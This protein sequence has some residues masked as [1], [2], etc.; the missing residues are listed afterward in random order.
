MT[1]SSH[2]LC[3]TQSFPWLSSELGYPKKPKGWLGTS[4]FGHVQPDGMRPIG[5]IGVSDV[6][7]GIFIAEMGSKMWSGIMLFVIWV[8]P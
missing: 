3:G 5:A 8:F 1:I 4:I 6:F 2:Q 7:E